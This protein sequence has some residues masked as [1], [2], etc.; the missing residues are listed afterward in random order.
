MRICCC[1]ADKEGYNHY[2]HLK[3]ILCGNVRE[4]PKRIPESPDAVS[5]PIIGSGRVGRRNPI[6]SASSVSRN[7]AVLT[8]IFIKYLLRISSV[9]GKLQVAGIMITTQ[10]AIFSDRIGP[11][12]RSPR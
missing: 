3:A 5:V 4:S 2:H 6:S 10:Q 9:S 7:D 1:V 11:T 8:A 12:S